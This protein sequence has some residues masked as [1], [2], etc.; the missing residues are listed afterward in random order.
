MSDFFRRNQS[1]LWRWLVRSTFQGGD[2]MWC[3]EGGTIWR[4]YM[5]QDLAK[6]SLMYA[7]LHIE[8]LHIHCTRFP[9]LSCDSDK[10]CVLSMK[11]RLH[12]CSPAYSLVGLHP[13]PWETRHRKQAAQLTAPR[14]ITYLA[15]SGIESAVIFILSWRVHF[16]VSFKFVE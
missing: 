9:S 3:M 5:D 4:H 7:S 12:R 2:T 1:W 8:W 11:P 16:L 15:L 13:M 14:R 10:S 6:C